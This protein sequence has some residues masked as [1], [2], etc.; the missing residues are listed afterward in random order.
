MRKI[1][2]FDDHYLYIR[3]GVATED[4]LRTSLEK[5]I[6]RIGEACRYKIN[7]VMITDKV[8]HKELYAGYSHVWIENLMIAYMLTNREPDGLE[9]FYLDDQ[10]RR[11]Y[12]DP[13][14]TLPGYEYTSEQRLHL[15]QT[16]SN[17]PKKGYFEVDRD[18]VSDAPGKRI[19]SILV[20]VGIA[21]WID[22]DFLYNQ[23]KRYSTYSEYPTIKIETR[24]NRGYYKRI[25]F[26]TFNSN[27]HDGKFAL[28]MS[29]RTKFINPQDENNYCRIYFNYY[30]PNEEDFEP[31]RMLGRPP[32]L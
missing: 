17:V 11:I 18:R 24:Q 22:E 32:G 6:R 20:G 31:K 29:K 9:R 15:E 12:Q 5:V 21:E 8:S 1:K 30:T 10:D 3:T 4:Q 25:C 19:T 7:M 28:A 14:I 16:D 27:T 2:Y 23:F 13:L 26:I